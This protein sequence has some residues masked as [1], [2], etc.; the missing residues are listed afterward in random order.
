[1]LIKIF[2]LIKILFHI[3]FIKHWIDYYVVKNYTPFVRLIC[4]H[5]FLV[6]FSRLIYIKTHQ[7]FWTTFIHRNVDKKCIQWLIL[8]S[9]FKKM[10]LLIGNY[11]WEGYFNLYIIE[12]YNYILLYYQTKYEFLVVLTSL[13]FLYMHVFRKIG[14]I[15]IRSIAIW[16]VWQ[17]SGQSACIEHCDRVCS[18]LQWN[19][20]SNQLTYMPIHI[21]SLNTS[22]YLYRV[23]LS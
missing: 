11:F 7:H 8:W 3:P 15:E 20:V 17:E 16:N 9:D 5:Y 14:K 12:Y 13:Y 6:R 23:R 10:A 21:T 4:T 18:V 19:A 1:M 2:K 22:I